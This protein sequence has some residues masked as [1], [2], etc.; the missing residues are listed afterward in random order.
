MTRA[1][2]LFRHG[3]SAWDGQC[4]GEWISMWR[5]AAMTATPRRQAW[6]RR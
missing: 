2:L 1:Y 4:N 3:I 5:S 6:W